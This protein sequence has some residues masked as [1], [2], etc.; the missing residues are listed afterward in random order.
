M[1]PR[2]KGSDKKAGGGN[3]PTKGTQPRVTRPAVRQTQP[4]DRRGSRLVAMRV[5]TRKR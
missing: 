1:I 3:P 4:H 5:R 2:P